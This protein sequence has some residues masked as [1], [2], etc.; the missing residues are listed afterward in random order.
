MNCQKNESKLTRFKQS[1]ISKNM[2]RLKPILNFLLLQKLPLKSLKLRKFPKKLNN[3]LPKYPNPKSKNKLQ[4]LKQQ[5]LLKRKRH[6][7][8]RKSLFLHRRKQV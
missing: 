3:Q 5:S 1:K 8:L 2:K 7:N 4:N 6:P